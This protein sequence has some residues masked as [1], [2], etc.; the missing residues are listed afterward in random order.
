MKPDTPRVLLDCVALVVGIPY[1]S[2]RQ[3]GV[4]VLSQDEGT[5]WRVVRFP[6]EDG[7]GDVTTGRFAKG[8]SKLSYS[9][10]SARQSSK[11]SSLRDSRV[12]KVEVTLKLGRDRIG[13][14][15]D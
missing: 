6:A 4:I 8:L 13:Q 3:A 15:S 1:K 14:G 9:K 2:S 7:K 10:M 12:D 11:E 5:L